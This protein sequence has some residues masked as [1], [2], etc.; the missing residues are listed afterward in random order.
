M[1]ISWKRRCDLNLA[2]VS[3]TEYKYSMFFKKDYKCARIVQYSRNNYKVY[4]CDLKNDN[5]L[6]YQYN[7]FTKCLE[8]VSEFFSCT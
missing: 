3:I 6:D 5:L 8:K 2:R 4:V 1:K 7:T